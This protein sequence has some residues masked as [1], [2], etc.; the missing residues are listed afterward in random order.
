MDPRINTAATIAV[1]QLKMP[2]MSLGHQVLGA[3]LL[4]QLLRA[5]PREG[6][7]LGTSPSPKC[8]LFFFFLQEEPLLDISPLSCLSSLSNVT[9]KT[10]I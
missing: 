2:L 10:N 6:E 5:G 3:K 4:P 8:L 1:L 9:V 7:G